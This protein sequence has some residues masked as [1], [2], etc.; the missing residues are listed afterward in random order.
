MKLSLRI[1][2]EDGKQP[3]VVYATF[4]DFCAFEETFNRS[5]VKLEQD[6][7]L[8]DLGWLAWNVCR[9]LKKTSLEYVK[10]RETVAGVSP[11]GDDDMVPLESS[12]PIGT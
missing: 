5:I 12:Q 9:R 7:R 8:T 3:E 4:N 2:W 1:E 10:W 11:V 6:L